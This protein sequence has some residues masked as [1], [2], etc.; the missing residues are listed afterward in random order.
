[1]SELL[2]NELD[3]EDGGDFKQTRDRSKAYC[4]KGGQSILMLDEQLYRNNLICLTEE[5]LVRAGKFHRTQRRSI[6]INPQWGNK[7]GAFPKSKFAF[8]RRDPLETPP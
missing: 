3:A 2:N 1:V 4:S 7:K 8:W 6:I 5:T